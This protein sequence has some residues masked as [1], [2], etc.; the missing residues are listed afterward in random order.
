MTDYSVED[1]V[2]GGSTT[3]TAVP[4]AQFRSLM[5]TFPTGVAIVTAA[6]LDG[7][8]WGMTCSSVCSVAVEPPTLLVCLREGSPTLAAMLRRSTFAVN[9]LHAR[10]RA[11]ADLFASG[12]PHRFDLV[13]WSCDPQAAGPHLADDA[14]AI[15]DC[16][17]SGTVRVGDHTV[18][19]GEAYRITHPVAADRSPLLYGL[20]T[21]S[22][23]PVR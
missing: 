2:L 7:R 6:D 12:A 22:S 14:H 10:A 3:V 8:T 1:G 20:R 13:R 11:T 17:I 23:W 19:F 21:Y 9:L 5:S 16:R 15:A 4:A 18:V